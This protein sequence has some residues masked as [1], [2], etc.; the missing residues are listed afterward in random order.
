MRRS[1]VPTKYPGVY[2]VGSK[3]YRVRATAIDPRTGKKRSEE[4]LVSGVSAQQ[5][6]RVRAELIE[7]IR[8]PTPERKRVRVGEFAQSWM[9][10]KTLKLDRGTARTYADALDNHVLPVLGDFFYDTLTTGDVQRWVDASLQS[11][12]T[13]KNAKSEAEKSTRRGDSKSHRYSRHSVHVWFRVFRT[14]TRDAM[15]TLAL[16]RDPTLRVSFPPA[17]ERDDPNTLGPEELERFLT[18]MRE[19]YPQHYALVVLLAYT[20]LRFCHA[21]ALRWD[22]WD[23]ERGV[24]RVVRKQVRGEV[25]PVSNKK[26]APREYPVEPELADVLKAHRRS[27]LARQAPGI[28]K[29]WMF[30]SAAGTLRTPSSLTKAWNATLKAAGIHRRF[31]V[32]G[33]RYTFTDLVRRANV[34][35]VVR[36]A[37]TGHVTEEMQRHYSNVSLDEK[38]AAVAGVIR[39]VPASAAAGVNSGV[40]RGRN[41]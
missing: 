1:G 36:R 38:R 41:D 28:E 17:P 29:G 32:H 20:G 27:L 5:A 24:V 37:L 3:E 12:W 39:L 9:K 10:S 26:R 4:K 18:T 23:E 25:G 16:P 30:P 8:K 15:D 31:T 6:A 34:D 22:D 33:L 11:V 2:K 35:V 21:S 7:G 14:M 40:N 13:T 19:R